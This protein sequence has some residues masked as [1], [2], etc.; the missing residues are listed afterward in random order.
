M[1]ASPAKNVSNLWF[2]CFVQGALCKSTDIN[3]RLEGST[4]PGDVNVRVVDIG[5]IT[6]YSYIVYGSLA[7]VTQ[8]TVELDALLAEQ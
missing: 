1:V 6:D 2:R 7:T 8:H 5:W 3:S 4:P